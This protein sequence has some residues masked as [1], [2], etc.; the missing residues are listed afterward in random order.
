MLKN[1]K[2]GRGEESGVG[3]RRS[4]IL[5]KMGA[6]PRLWNGEKVPQKVRDHSGWAN[7]EVWHWNSAFIWSLS[8]CSL[9]LIQI[10]GKT[11]VRKWLHEAGR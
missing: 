8:L 4:K 5:Q 11:K 1:K 9:A 2:D 10:S 7:Y 3:S 6:E